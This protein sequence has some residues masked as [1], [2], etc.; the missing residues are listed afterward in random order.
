MS[1]PETPK[2]WLIAGPNGSG[3]TT[4]VDRYLSKHE[5]V[6]A[7]VIA[8]AMNP[9]DP[10]AVA[11]EAMFAAEAKR[12]ELLKQGKTFVAETVF[13]HQSKLDLLREAKQAG[14]NVQLVFI[15]TEDP[16]LNAGRV[17]QRVA[18]GG[19]AV[20]IDKIGPRYARSI[21]NAQAAVSMVDRMHLYDN[22][23]TNMPHKFVALFE[24]GR[25]ESAT[26]QP[27]EWFKA[28]FGKEL[29][30]WQAAK[31]RKRER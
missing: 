13:S 9:V 5:F 28:A 4:F 30:Q 6:N 15:C 22:T 3:K 1:E 21:A 2:L 31:G 25:L 12:K 20:P 19:H 27:P 16:A 17:M 18:K 8:K 29:E 24:N 7:D 10:G 23:R 11:R 26:K 14:Y